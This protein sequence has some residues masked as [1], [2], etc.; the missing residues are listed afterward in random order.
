[1]ERQNYVELENTLRFNGI[2]WIHTY[3]IRTRPLPMRSLKIANFWLSFLRL[4][5]FKMNMGYFMT[6]WANISVF[7]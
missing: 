1:M 7:S 5:T 3:G 6:F 2:I 4:L